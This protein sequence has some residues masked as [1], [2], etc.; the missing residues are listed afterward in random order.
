[1]SIVKDLAL[2]A[3]FAIA[4]S[5]PAVALPEQNQLDTAQLINALKGGG[6]VMYFRHGVTE[7]KEIDKAK[8][9][10]DEHA[11]RDNSQNCKTQRNLSAQ[12]REKARAMGLAIAALKIPIGEVYSSPFCRC[13]DTAWNITLGQQP[14]IS[15]NLYFAAKETRQGKAKLGRLLKKMLAT[16]P[17]AG[18]NTILVSHTSNLKEA[19]DLW[20]KPEGVAFIFKTRANGEID[21]AGKILPHEWH[22]LNHAVR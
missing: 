17:K 16:A 6:Y 2:L 12:G 22:S 19:V 11:K 1:M 3:I 20:P 14:Q 13:V 9:D 5:T 8:I 21:F 7:H 10:V 15:N 4:F 18:T